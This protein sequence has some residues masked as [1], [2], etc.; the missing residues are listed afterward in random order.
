MLGIVAIESHLN[1][2]MIVGE[3]IGNVP[4]GFLDK[5]A[6]KNI[7]SMSVLWSERWDAGWGDFKSPYQYPETW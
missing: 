2:C 4:E 7:M 6:A 3:S 1:R 5:I